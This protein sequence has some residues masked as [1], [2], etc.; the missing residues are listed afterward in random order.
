MSEISVFSFFL[1]FFSGYLS[2]TTLWDLKV[3]DIQYLHILPT[4]LP[5][6]TPQE[7]HVALEYVCYRTEIGD[8]NKGLVR[9][10]HRRTWERENLE[11]NWFTGKGKSQVSRV[12]QCNTMCDA[13]YVG[14]LVMMNRSIYLDKCLG[15]MR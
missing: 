2:I 11:G 15:V 6:Y 4:Y 9:T 8:G 12:V 3:C 7:F 1:S 10:W 14:S 5:A 13:T